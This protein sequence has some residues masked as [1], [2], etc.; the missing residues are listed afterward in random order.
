MTTFA[1]GGTSGI[2]PGPEPAPE[3]GTVAAGGSPWRAIL[4]VFLQNRLAIVGVA[5]VILMVLF[6]FVGP[7]VYHTDQVHTNLGDINMPPGGAHPLGTDD[8]GYDVLGRLM[9]SGQSSLMV[10]LAAAVLA[11]VVG[12]LWGAVAGYAGGAV[13]AVMMRIVD[14]VLAI[15]PL[16]LI[17]L[18]ASVFRQNIWTLILIVAIVSWLAPARLVRGE[19]ISLR[20]REYVQAATA[21]GGRRGWIVLRHITPNAI[22]TIVVQ[23]TFEVAN[24]ILLLAALSYLGLGPAPPATNW[25]SMLSNGL[26]YMYEGKWWLIYPAGLAI[27]LTVVAFNFIGDAMR[28][29]LEVRL[30]ER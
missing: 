5:I 25:G 20:T 2:A 24:A 4:S 28:A 16:I 11:T 7:L 17:L 1:A 10:G 15:P 22:G 3:G 13:D 23:A 30:R 21:M 9:L 14:S 26:N 27:V 8:V 6:S 29:A 19:A 12:T 18:L